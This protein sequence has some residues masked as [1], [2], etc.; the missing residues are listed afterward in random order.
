MELDHTERTEKVLEWRREGH[1]FSEIGRRL[2]VTRQRA[3][4]LWEQ[5]NLPAVEGRCWCGVE[6]PRVVQ[7]GRPRKYCKPEHMPKAPYQRK[8]SATSCSVCGVVFDEPR[9]CLTCADCGKD[10]RAARV[11]YDE[12][13]D[14]QGHRCAICHRPETAVSK[15]GKPRKLSI[16]HCHESGKTRE[17]LCMKCNIL[18]GSAKDDPNILERAVAYLMKHAEVVAA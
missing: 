6:L 14:K 8:W 9:K 7:S 5:A 2:G 13:A 1:T 3:T 15:L 17:L 12:L 11:N 18:L 4:T 10:Y 16:D